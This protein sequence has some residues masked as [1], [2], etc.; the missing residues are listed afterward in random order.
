MLVVTGPGATGFIH[1]LFRNQPDASV[2]WL[3]A[4]DRTKMLN[5]PHQLEESHQRKNFT[6]RNFTARQYVR[7]VQWKSFGGGDAMNSGGPNILNFEPWDPF[8]VLSLRYNSILPPTA[9]A[10]R[11]ITAF[12]KHGYEE[13]MPLKR[14]ENIGTVGRP[15][16]IYTSDN[17]GRPMIADTL[18][19]RVAAL[20][21][22]T[23]VLRVLIKNDES[24]LRAYGV[25]AKSVATGDEQL[26]L[27]NK[28]VLAAS[29]FGTFNLLVNSG[30]GPARALEARAINPLVVN[31]SVGANVG[32]ELAVPVVFVNAETPSPPPPQGTNIKKKAN[33]KCNECL[34]IISAVPGAT[35]PMASSPALCSGFSLNYVYVCCEASYRIQWPPCLLTANVPL[36]SGP[37]VWTLLQVY[38]CDCRL[39]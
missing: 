5:W 14:V 10:D 37:V 28:V 39:V 1:R 16:S 22:E 30:V 11:F 7:N 29:V 17:Q 23:E 38:W 36:Q 2:C 4:G 6:F 35:L 21:L 24:T 34:K 15:S 13:K 8:N 32:D 9:T 12:T 3:E 20:H 18:A 19:G 27:G 31:E 25:V 26:F 33:R